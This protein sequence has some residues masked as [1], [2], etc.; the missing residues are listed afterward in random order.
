MRKFK[1]IG[2]AEKPGEPRLKEGN[3]FRGLKAP[4]F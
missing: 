1:L 4:F 3:F 2:W